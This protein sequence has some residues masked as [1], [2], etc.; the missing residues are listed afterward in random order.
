[1]Q[2]SDKH[3]VMREDP[4]S[5]QYRSLEDDSPDKAPVNHDQQ[6][7]SWHKNTQPGKEDVVGTWKGTTKNKIGEPWPTHT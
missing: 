3:K 4:Y 2:K 6:A 7:H 1:M 5:Q